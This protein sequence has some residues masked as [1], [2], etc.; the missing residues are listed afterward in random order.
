[1]VTAIDIFCLV[2]AMVLIYVE[3]QRGIWVAALDFAG[4]LGAIFLAGY[5]YRP[6][7]EWIPAPSSAYFV[8]LVVALVVVAGIS[9]Y[10]SMRTKE[11][12]RSWECAGGAL[13]GLFTS[14][15]I[16]YGIFRFI[17]MKYGAGA[18]FVS[19]SL[20]AYML[21]EKG[22]LHEWSGFMRLLMG[23]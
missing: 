18:P 1:M 20:L 3:A 11:Q 16:C 2:I 5:A 17:T 22:V 23:R 4:A 19:D 7:G 21:A 14:L 8:V 13:M 10:V 15:T 12:V 9:I 6:L